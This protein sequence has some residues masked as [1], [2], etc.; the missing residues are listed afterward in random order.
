[1]KKTSI[2]LLV[3]LGIMI[4]GYGIQHFVEGDVG[5]WSGFAGVLALFGFCITLVVIK[6]KDF[7]K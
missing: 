6:L 4:V 7:R 3:F 1:M 2:A 5:V